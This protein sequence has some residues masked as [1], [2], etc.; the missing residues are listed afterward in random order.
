[1]KNTP[2]DTK[3]AG[4]PATSIINWHRQTIVLNKLVEF[5]TKMSK[6]G[7]FNKVKTIF[8]YFK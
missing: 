3:V 7:F 5:T 2:S 4:S 6:K 1:M 8:S